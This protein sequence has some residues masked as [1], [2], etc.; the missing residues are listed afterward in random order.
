MQGLTKNQV[1]H[2]HT[3]NENIGKISPQNPYSFCTSINLEYTEDEDFDEIK[4]IFDSVV[5]AEASSDR[6]LPD[7]FKIK[8]SGGYVIFTSSWLA[9]ELLNKTIEINEKILI[10][11]GASI[12]QVGEF[13]DEARNFIK[14]SKITH[15]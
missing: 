7:K 8:L 9:F 10:A 12:D 2:F 15:V 1:L 14:E 3:Y 5:H 4:K 6:S 11:H 13:T